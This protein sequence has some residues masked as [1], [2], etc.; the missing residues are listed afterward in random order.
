MS[1]LETGL[2]QIKQL[3]RNVGKETLSAVGPARG[4]A[5]SRKYADVFASKLAIEL[6]LKMSNPVVVLTNFETEIIIEGDTKIVDKP[7]PIAVVAYVNESGK[8]VKPPIL[9]DLDSTAAIEY[10]DFKTVDSSNLTTNVLMVLDLSTRTKTPYIPKLPRNILVARAKRVGA[11][12]FGI[13]NFGYHITIWFPDLASMVD[14]TRLANRPE[15]IQQI[16]NDPIKAPGLHPAQLVLHRNS[17]PYSGNF[18]VSSKEN[19]DLVIDPE[20]ISPDL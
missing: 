14:T 9:A 10:K 13:I 2:E 11:K 20:D 7:F 18:T 6:E 19:V 15:A 4:A 12:L 17:S 8:V 1:N 16:Q 3:L 5:A